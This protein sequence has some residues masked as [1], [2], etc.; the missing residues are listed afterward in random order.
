VQLYA[1]KPAIEGL[2][3]P[4]KELMAFAKTNSL[5]PGEEAVITLTIPVQS[6]SYYD[7]TQS[8]WVVTPGKYNFIAAASAEDIRQQKS[9]EIE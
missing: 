5:Q 7:E 4:A 3:M 1:S 9:I 2:L 6:L 8:T